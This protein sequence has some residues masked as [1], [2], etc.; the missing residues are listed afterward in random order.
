MALVQ[1]D[2]VPAQ[3]AM[4]LAQAAMEALEQVDTD[5][6]KVD[7]VLAKDMVTTKDNLDKDI[8]NKLRNT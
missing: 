2:T 3:A 5:P 6:T 1:V 8:W 7:M 4:V